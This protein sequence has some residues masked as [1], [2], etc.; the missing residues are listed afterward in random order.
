MIEN[1]NEPSHGLLKFLLA[2]VLLALIVAFVSVLASI[3]SCHKTDKEKASETLAIKE[4]DKV[5]SSQIASD[6]QLIVSEKE[7]KK[8]KKDVRELQKELKKLQDEINQLHSEVRQPKSPSAHSATTQ[9]ATQST[10]LSSIA[11]ISTNDITLSNYSHDWI[12]S[13]ATVALKNNTNKTITFVAG[14]IYYYDMSGNMLDYQDFTKN[15]T[16]EP[17]LVKSF[18]LKGYGHMEKYAYYKSEVSI[19]NPGR[20]YKVKFELKSYKSK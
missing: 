18:K 14:R 16:I 19:S 2:L 17:G 9:P 4:S 8:L 1:N 6:D 5:S 13:D 11:T 20:K 15:V 7:W 10:T 3:P 12:Q